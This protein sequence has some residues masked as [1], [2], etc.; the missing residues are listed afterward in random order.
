MFS[1]SCMA[2]Y[3]VPNSRLDFRHPHQFG[4]SLAMHLKT[5]CI[6]VSVAMHL[7]TGCITVSV[8]MHLKNGLSSEW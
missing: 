8:A 1:I 2:P 3:N 7:K 4:P 5:G 6:T